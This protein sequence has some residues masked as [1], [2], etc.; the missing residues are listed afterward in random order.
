MCKT[1]SVLPLEINSLSD[2]VIL[3]DTL[4]EFTIKLTQTEYIFR[5]TS[6]KFE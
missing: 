2:S 1:N 6:Y 4:S 3:P 5:L